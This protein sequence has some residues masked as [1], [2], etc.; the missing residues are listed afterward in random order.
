MTNDLNRRIR[1]HKRGK[2]KTTKNK[3]ISRI[4][5]IERCDGRKLARNR[6]KYWKSGCGKEF[7][8][9]KLWGRSSV[10]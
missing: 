4:V 5:I 7:L 10:G 1:E 8:K 2:T 9:I 6:E 3:I